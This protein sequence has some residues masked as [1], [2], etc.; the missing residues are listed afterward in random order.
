MKYILPM[1]LLSGCMQLAP[2]ISGEYD[3]THT[4]TSY[5]G[6]HE[7][8]DRELLQRFVIVNPA[9]TE[10]CAAFVNAT[11]RKDGKLGSWANSDYP[12]LAK[13]FLTWGDRV[14]LENIQRGDVVIFNRGDEGWQGHV[15]FYIGSATIEGKKKLGI[16]GGNQDDSVSYAFYDPSKVV[17]IRRYKDHNE[18]ETRQ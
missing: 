13:S 5:L 17:G 11:L 7:I 4:A 3:P 2:E 1:L 18:V 10:W 9:T 15:G 16:L 14:E 6:T 12:L 8:R